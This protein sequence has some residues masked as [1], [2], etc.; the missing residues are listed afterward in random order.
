MS[1]KEPTM[2][3]PN[4]QEIVDSPGEIW[5]LPEMKDLFDDEIQ[6]DDSSMGDVNFDLSY[7]Y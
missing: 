7:D 6:F 4:W 2:F 5:D 3:D 1:S